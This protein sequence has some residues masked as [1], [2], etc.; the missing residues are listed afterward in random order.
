[1]IF[2]NFLKGKRT[3][4]SKFIKLLFKYIK[5]NIEF[6]KRQNVPIFAYKK[7]FSPNLDEKR[8]LN[9]MT[10][11]Y[12]KEKFCLI[13]NSMCKYLLS[14]L[15]I[16]EKKCFLLKMKCLIFTFAEIQTTFSLILIIIY[17]NN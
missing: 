3:R 2:I 14:K 11:I 10:F 7:Y 5:P 17:L 12:L 8:Y 6:L 13:F 16:L 1:M 4:I 15:T 9:E